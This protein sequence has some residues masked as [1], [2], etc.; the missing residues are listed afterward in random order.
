MTQGKT[1]KTDIPESAPQLA[2]AIIPLLSSLVDDVLKIQNIHGEVA[3][4][5]KRLS[6][7]SSQVVE[8]KED[9]KKDVERLFERYEGKID[10][11][12][13][14][15]ETD[16]IAEL[17]KTLFD[18]NSKNITQKDFE[19]EIEI[20]SKDVECIKDKCNERKIEFK[21]HEEKDA[22]LKKEIYILFGKSVIITSTVV[23][24]LLQVA[25][26]FLKDYF[27]S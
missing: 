16:R 9:F 18:K 13:F 8:Y 24:V 20:L 23:T 12:T 4:L 2:E 15:R 3:F 11:E 7:L 21:N 25:L 10:K 22:D 19:R 14:E 26:H 5:E 17:I 6:F 27:S 1:N